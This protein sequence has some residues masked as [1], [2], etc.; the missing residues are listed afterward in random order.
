MQRELAQ[1]V[2]GVIGGQL[3]VTKPE[4][5]GLFCDSF[6]FHTFYK[7]NHCE[8]EL[9]QAIESGVEQLIIIWVLLGR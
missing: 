1:Q 2:L 9:V 3:A 5:V 7:P 8:G 4:I 6:A